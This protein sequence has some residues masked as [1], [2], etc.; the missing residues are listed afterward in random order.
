MHWPLVGFRSF[1]GI[2]PIRQYQMVQETLERIVV[3]C[4][5]DEPLTDSQK[6]ALIELIQS[7]L[8]Y[9]FALEILDQRNDLPRQPGGK[10]EE[11][12]SNVS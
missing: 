8:G 5:T 1:A 7:K 9:E 12:I 10:F 6:T 3:H 11:F 2:A 4:V